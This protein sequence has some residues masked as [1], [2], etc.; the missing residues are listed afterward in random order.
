M[1]NK[2][3]EFTITAN[4]QP[5]E[6]SMSKL[7]E[8]VGDGTKS[9]STFAKKLES[10]SSIKI[11]GITKALNSE[12]KASQVVVA[13]I[14]KELS[15][16]NIQAD[17]YMYPPTELLNGIKE[18]N[19]ELVLAENTAN[20]FSEAL[21]ASK[22]AQ[23][24]ANLDSTFKDYIADLNI[25]IGDM[26]QFQALIDNATSKEMKD[27]TAQLRSGLEEAEND[28]SELQ[29][30]LISAI[31][32]D[33]SPRAIENLQTQVKDATA[34]VNDFK[35]ALDQVGKTGANQG[36]V[37]SGMF[38]FLKGKV[39]NV[40]E[41][42][43]A[44]AEKFK[45]IAISS[46]VFSA[47][48]AIKTGLSDACKLSDSA[49][50]K[51]TAISNVIAGSLIPI[52]ETFANAIRKAIVWVAGLVKFITGFD[53]LKAGIDAT[54]K[55][56]QKLGKNSKKTGK[57]VKDGLLSSLDE[58]TNIQPSQ[59][60]GSSGGGGD[61]MAAQVGAMGELTSMMEEMNALD[62]S[63]AE[64]LKAVWEFLCEYGDV[65]AIVLV[66]V[67]VAIGV[68]NV[69][70]WVLSA[71][72]IVLIIAAIIVAIG[73][74]IAIIVLCVKHWDEICA[75]VE[76]VA[77]AIWDWICNL[78]EAIG[79]WFSDLWDG[80]VEIFSQVVGFFVGVFQGA[81]DGIKA[82]WNAVV[83]FFKGIWEGIKAIF[84]FVVDYYKTIF[85]TAWT[86]IKTVW[87]V[88]VSW[89]KGIWDGIKNVFSAVG[90]WFKNIFTNAYNGV[91]NVF[92][93]ITGFFK[94]I[95]DSIKEIF[96]KVGQVI[97]DAITNTVKKAVNTVLSMAVKIINGFISAINVAIS[98]IN[99][100]PGVNIKKLDKLEVPSFDVGTDFV[101]EDMLAMI[102]KG[103]RIVPAKYNDDNYGKAE[104]D[105]SETNELLE[106]LITIVA[107]KNFT[108]S[109]DDIGRA[110]VN[111]I[112]AESR[113]RG[114]SVI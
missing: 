44:L 106:N 27:I 11:D 41:G 52:V 103:E 85:T 65:L 77:G 87:N 92:S 47:L 108:I 60:G 102:H 43:K 18:C 104:V 61:D 57:Q 110:S 53:M 6:K 66:A 109:G 2:E 12:L 111:Y 34:R 68:V 73:L 20:N 83:G 101:P 16:L 4:T 48:G 84:N 86:V 56:I 90:S 5:L 39:E 31:Q 29:M 51:F 88:V 15:N 100:I 58:I 8:D 69:A 72:P 113:R 96:S 70:M 33:A 74:L 35:K 114:E 91:V 105:M 64:P 112:N 14:K 50:N 98:V 23:G 99:A 46:V 38:N 107:N 76:E 78:V 19:D 40:G 49:T 81:W 67:A 1:E 10:M 7:I 22:I 9:I 97:G 59:G 63:W 54:N 93:K 21:D 95:W 30:K 79:Q 45:R 24:M 25:G 26:Q 89:F 13:D 75:K 42:V 32:Y 71:N 3:I 82:V 55:N 28:L 94:G 17:G 36:G 37:L 62:F 80:I